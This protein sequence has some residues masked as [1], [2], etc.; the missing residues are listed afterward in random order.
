MSFNIRY[1]LLTAILFIIEV[2]IA[3]YIHDAIIR[4]YGGDFLVVILIYCFVKTFFNWPVIKTA[5]GT[6]IFSYL[7]EIGQYFHL[8]NVLGLERFKLARIV[9]GV[10]FSFID[11]LCYTM[12]II[13]VVI[14]ERLLSKK[15]EAFC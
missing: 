3:L 12:G 7:V 1:F 8:V 5:L 11:L 10:G 15:Y 13:L 14:V 6:L 4:P 9:I 2:L